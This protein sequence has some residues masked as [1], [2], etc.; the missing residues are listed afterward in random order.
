[1]KPA[2]MVGIAIV[3]I[4]AV[5]G[6]GVT[7]TIN[8]PGLSPKHK[9][10]K[11]VAGADAPPDTTAKPAPQTPPAPPKVVKKPKP[12]DSP[13]PTEDPQKGAKRLAAVWNEMDPTDLEAITK[14]WKEGDVV[15]VLLAMDAA[16]V[17]EFLTAIAAD[18]PDL[19]S[20]L[21]K[22]YQKQSAQIA[23]SDAAS[24]PM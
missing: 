17:A 9:A 10:A 14:G 18:K 23:K 6:L 2:V 16:K 13:I 5:V 11:P 24:K 12:P 4:G 20:K 8:I 22:T 15:R 1:M 19:A 7:G 21:S 3:V